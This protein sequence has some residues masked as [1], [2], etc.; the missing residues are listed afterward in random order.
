MSQSGSW[1]KLKTFWDR[2]QARMMLKGCGIMPSAMLEDLDKVYT[3]Q[4][5]KMI[6]DSSFGCIGFTCSG[7][8]SRGRWDAFA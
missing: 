4:L 8:C 3:E 6:K 5:L 7:H 1:F 2:L